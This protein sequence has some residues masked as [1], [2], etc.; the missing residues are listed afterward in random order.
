M[1]SHG[2]NVRLRPGTEPID[3]SAEPQQIVILPQPQY[4]GKTTLALG[5][6]NGLLKDLTYIAALHGGSFVALGSNSRHANHDW[7]PWPPG[8]PATPARD[9][10][11][12]DSIPC[13]LGYRSNFSLQA[14]HLITPSFDVDETGLFRLDFIDEGL[15]VLSSVLLKINHHHHRL[16][17][18]YPKFKERLITKLPFNFSLDV[19]SMKIS[20]SEV[21]SPSGVS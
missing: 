14:G 21:E 18:L 13:P 5:Q 19:K 9:K 17:H 11:N 7:I 20:S 6:D 2:M 1:V 10:V 15:N 3:N 8:T 12:H 16:I 4:W